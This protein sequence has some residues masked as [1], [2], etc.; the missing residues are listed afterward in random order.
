MKRYAVV[1]THGMDED[2]R[3]LEEYLTEKATREI[4]ERFI[5]RL[6]V[7]CESLAM[8]PYRGAKRSDLRA[9]MRILGFKHAVAV[10]FRVEEEKGLVVV[11][12]LSYR[13]RSIKRI[14]ER[15]E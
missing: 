8:A 10:V 6:A 4:A 1:F 13:G 15:D 14:L 11:L 5:D 9:N 3:E 2:A 12:G 7:E